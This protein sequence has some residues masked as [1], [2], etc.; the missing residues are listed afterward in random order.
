[1][2]AIQTCMPCCFRRLTRQSSMACICTAAVL[3]RRVFKHLFA[4][5]L[6][7]ARLL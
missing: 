6:H 1:L 5:E 7:R 4:F 3:M 2:L